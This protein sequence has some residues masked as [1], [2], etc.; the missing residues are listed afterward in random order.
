M[1]S[2]IIRNASLG[3]R[4]FTMSFEATFE[5]AEPG[6]FVMIRSESSFDPL[7][8]RPMSIAGFHDGIVNIIYCVVGRGTTLFAEKQAGEYIDVIGPFGNYFNPPKSADTLL[9][10]MGGVGVAPLL[11]FR[12]RNKERNLIAL[13]GSATDFKD[14]REGFVAAGGFS[15][16]ETAT[17]DGSQGKKGL[18]TDLLIKRREWGKD[19]SYVLACGPTGM[20]KAVDAL[21]AHHGMRGELSLEERMGCGFGV[22]LGCV[23]DTTGGRKRMCVEGPVFKT[24]EVLWRT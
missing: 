12:N 5:N 2:K 10:V 1:K 17:M 18:V 8:R 11:F 19:S 14:V 15:E 6:Q 13:F 24:G 3:Q 21:C 7:L 16:Y 23:C 20:L 9:C 4:Y 22:C